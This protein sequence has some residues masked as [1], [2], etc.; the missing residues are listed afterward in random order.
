[1]S[2]L[3][4]K[5]H[6]E[7]VSVLHKEFGY[8]SAMEVPRLLKITVNM[9]VGEAVANPKAIEAAYNDMTK[10]AGQKPQITKAKKSIAAYKLREGMEIGVMATLRRMRMWQFLDRMISV[11]LPRVRDFR[12]L[13]RRGFD[14][15]GNYSLGVREQIIFPEISYDDIDKIRGMNITMN[16]SARN[17]E[18]GLRLLELLG[19]PFRRA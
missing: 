14:G 16:T 19:V 13:S 15:H 17:D 7:V 8:T 2:R 9:G 11:A 1:M 12:G 3:Q 5:Y 6:Q 10:V 18:E 4:Q